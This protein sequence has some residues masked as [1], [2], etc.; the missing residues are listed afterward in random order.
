M[1]AACIAHYINNLRRH[2]LKTIKNAAD[3]TT[4]NG[5]ITFIAARNAKNLNG[6]KYDVKS[7]QAQDASGDYKALSSSDTEVAIPLMVDHSAQSHDKIGVI[8]KARIEA[9]DGVDAVI[10]HATFFDTEEAQVVRD[11]I[12]KNQL[13][14]VSITTDWGDGEDDEGNDLVNAH[15]IEVSVVYAGAEPKAKILAKNSVEKTEEEGVEVTEVTETKEVETT[16]TTEE[17]QVEDVETKETTEVNESEETVEET[18]EDEESTNDN[19]E[20]TE[21][22]TQKTEE[23]T[24][25][26]ATKK[27][28]LNSIVK[29]AKDNVIK[30]M[31]RS[32]V[33]EAVKNDLD[34]LDADGDP[35]SVPDAI[36]TEILAVT[37]DTDVLDTFQTVPVKRFT[38]MQ[39][40]LSEADLARAGRWTKGEQKQIQ[41]SDLKAQ[42]LSTQ[43]LYKLQELSYEDLQE[44]FGDIL[45]AFVHQ[46]L[47]QKVSE[48]EERDFIVGDGRATNDD[49]HISSI[50]S[51][52]EAAE[53][54]ANVH[55]ALY[56]GA[57]ASSDLEAL[58]LGVAQ[59]YEDGTLYAI[60]N[61]STLASLKNI[62]TSSASGLPFTEQQIADAIGVT[63]IFTR[64]YVP[65]G[66][67]YVYTGDKVKRLTGASAGETIEQYDIDYNNRKIEFI[68]PVGGAATGLYSAVKIVLDTQSS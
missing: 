15:I 10:M 44:D 37:R 55:V 42:K 51:L 4:D 11:R 60:V 19:E 2:D 27:Q 31:S 49:R 21:V 36:F 5:E 29:L 53:D 50:V 9:V 45:L 18:E 34:L 56:D 16:E 40:V 20:D 14:D 35:Y 8:D 61:K 47:P 52:D 41:E 33:I 23:V 54:V 43:F 26:V 7:L 63:K 68:R 46:E 48:E 38:L 28:V 12:V 59:I 65:E 39:E 62:G 66:V 57:A 17:T 58:T 64:S 3:V 25:N 30:G 22:P 6:W 24:E 13:T 1:A 32:Q 67:A